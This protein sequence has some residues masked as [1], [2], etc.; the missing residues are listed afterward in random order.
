MD[1]VLKRHIPC[2]GPWERFV[3][4]LSYL[5]KSLSSMSNAF[6]AMLTTMQCLVALND[7]IP[8]QEYFDSRSM[9]PS[10]VQPHEY[11]AGTSPRFPFKL[12]LRFLLLVAVRSRRFLA[13]RRPSL[14][15]ARQ[16]YNDEIAH[17]D[18]PGQCTV[19]NQPIP[20][21]SRQGQSESAIDRPE[22]H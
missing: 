3:M 21:I 12:R 11:R 22:H 15:P 6:I 19:R 5:K 7:I 14:P 2:P 10:T 9:L 4:S 18:H 17:I 8:T 16:Q 20:R 13:P 1:G